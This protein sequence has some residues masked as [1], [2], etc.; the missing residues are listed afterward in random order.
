MVAAEFGHYLDEFRWSDSE[1]E[2]L[3]LSIRAKRCTPF[4]GAGACA[5]LLPTATDLVDE[6][7]KSDGYPFT[8]GRSLDRVAQYVATVRDVQVPKLRIVEKF[9]SL[10]ITRPFDPSDEAH[11]LNRLAKLRQ[12]IYLTTNYDDYLVAA[13]TNEFNAGPEVACCDWYLPRDKRRRFKGLAPTAD[14]PLVYHLHGRYQD[15]PSMVLTEDDYLDFLTQVIDDKRLL[16]PA[17]DGAFGNSMFLFIGY[18]LT[19][20]N[21]RV[22][23]KKLAMYRAANAYTHVAVQLEPGDTQATNE[24]KLRQA[25]YLSKLYKDFLKVKLFWAT[26]AEFMRELTDRLGAHP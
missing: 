7:V 4:V 10:R 18:G 1:W 13:L 26:A 19:D 2:S 24:M 22:L 5:G 23:F 9:R 25:V 11:T 15:P 20:L 12:P 6:W 21:F 3:L 8:S 14:K 17:V 16:P